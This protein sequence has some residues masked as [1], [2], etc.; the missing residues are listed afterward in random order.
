MCSYSEVFWGFIIEVLEEL[1]SG[2]DVDCEG[3]RSGEVVL[4][5][6]VGEGV[7][8]EEGLRLVGGF[9]DRDCSGVPVNGGVYCLEPRHSQDDVIVSTV[10]YVKGFEVG[11]SFYLD[12]EGAK[13]MDV[14]SFIGHLVCISYWYGYV[15]SSSREMVFLYKVPVDAGD[16][17]T[18][19]NEGMR[20]NG[21]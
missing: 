11:Y 19:V 18:T 5:V 2:S 3:C 15:E 1:V 21:F 4:P 8:L 7:L 12:V 14:A 9:G 6:G 17:C 16:V 20:I 13:E 10:H